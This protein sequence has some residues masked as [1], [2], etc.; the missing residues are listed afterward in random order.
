MEGE[1]AARE[2]ESEEAVWA[3]GQFK[4]FSPKKSMDCLPFPGAEAT[5]IGGPIWG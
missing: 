5:R 1:E 2:W 3:E 4:H